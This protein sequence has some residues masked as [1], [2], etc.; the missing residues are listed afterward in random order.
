MCVFVCYHIASSNLQLD[1]KDYLSAINEIAEMKSCTTCLFFE[2]RKRKDLYLWMS[3]TPLGPSVKFYVLNG[4]RN[5]VFQHSITS[6]VSLSSIVVLSIAVHTM[7]ELRL[8]GN[9]LKGSRPM[10][11][12]DGGFDTAPHLQLLKELFVQ[13]FNVP[14]GHPKSQPFFDHVLSFSV[15]D[16][17]IWVRHYQVRT[18][19]L[20]VC[21][22][23]TVSVISSVCL[24]S[25]SPDTASLLRICSQSF[26]LS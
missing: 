26:I 18:S 23:A 6:R 8:T 9:C 3:K 13:V 22:P 21:V 2:V 24:P 5:V 11:S 16:G 25:V 7:D 20:N 12:F 4:M 19:L 14:R 15:L 1:A 10:L 17:K